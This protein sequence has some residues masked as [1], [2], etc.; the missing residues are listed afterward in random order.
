MYESRLIKTQKSYTEVSN[1]L[2]EVIRYTEFKT[3]FVIVA[4]CSPP[5]NI[6]NISV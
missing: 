6:I 2:V 3:I 4:M 5:E 1:E